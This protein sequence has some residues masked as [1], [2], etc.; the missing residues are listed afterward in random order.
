MLISL[1]EAFYGFFLA[2]QNFPR[3]PIGNFE[4]RISFLAVPFLGIWFLVHLRKN[5]DA[6]KPYRKVLL[7]LGILTTYLVLHVALYFHQARAIGFL[8]WYLFNAF[9]FVYVLALRNEWV[10]RGFICSLLWGSFHMILQR[11]DPYLWVSTHDVLENV[12]ISG[13]YRVFSWFGESS[14]AALNLLFLV[15]LTQLYE[16]KRWFWATL[17]TLLALSF[18]YS[19]LTWVGIPILYALLFYRAKGRPDRQ[20]NLGIQLACISAFLFFSYQVF[21]NR[22]KSDGVQP[23]IAAPADAKSYHEVELRTHYDLPSTALFIEV[24]LRDRTATYLRGWE[25]VKLNPLFGVGLGNSK[26]YIEENR[27]RSDINHKFEGV[28]SLYLEIAS[29]I[30]IVGLLFFLG[31]LAS[32]YLSFGLK[33]SLLPF[34]FTVLFLMQFC[35]NLN[36]P[37]IWLGLAACL[38]HRFSLLSAHE[39]RKLS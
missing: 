25:T 3:I 6:L 10:S 32:L 5:L 22:F 13:H 30:G 35:P 23:Q 29:E 36:M 27:V 39:S 4:L 14:Y 21:P 16:H 17:T 26:H 15:G 38:S 7:A 9:S 1:I 11:F 19:K 2:F 37:V 12:D 18:A 34:W 28:P 20:R 31:F 33:T 24:L 8:I